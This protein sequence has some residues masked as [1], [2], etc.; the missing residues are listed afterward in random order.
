[1]D[2]TRMSSMVKFLYAGLG[3][4]C[5][6]FSGCTSPKTAPSR[7]SISL[8]DLLETYHQEGLHLFPVTATNAGDPRYNDL[9]HNDIGP[10]HREKVKADR[11]SPR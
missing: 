2:L 11:P 9:L 10:E 1:M 6:C 8:A 5:I 3:L 7:V 4:L